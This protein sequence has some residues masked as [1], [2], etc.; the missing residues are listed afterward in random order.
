[1]RRCEPV[2][3]EAYPVAGRLV[4]GDVVGVARIAGRQHVV[5]RPFHADVVGETDCP[6]IADERSGGGATGVGEMV[7]RAALVIR[8]PPAPVLQRLVH[9]VE[10]GCRRD[11]EVSA[12]DFELAAVRAPMTMSMRLSTNWSS[13]RTG[14]ALPLSRARARSAA[15]R[16]MKTMQRFD[17][18]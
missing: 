12:H 10:L 4:A 15:A 9:G 6:T 7:E 3:I 1:M 11:L 16:P 18:S 17:R 14:W 2:H 8:A 5:L 13:D